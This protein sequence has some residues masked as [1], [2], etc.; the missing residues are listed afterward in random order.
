MNIKFAE[1]DSDIARCFA[2]MAQLYPYLGRQEF[3]GRIKHQQGQGYRLSYVEEAD[4][5][6]AVSGFR[7]LENLAHGRFLYVD[8]LKRFSFEWI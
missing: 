3:V 6:V 1:S 2:V 8:D 4:G 7:V 5:V